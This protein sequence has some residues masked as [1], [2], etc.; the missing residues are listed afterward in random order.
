MPN[1][2]KVLYVYPHDVK[3]VK[4]K[5]YHP[6]LS[7]ILKGYTYLSDD[8]TCVLSSRPLNNLSKIA[9]ETY[10]GNYPIKLIPRFNRL[11][12]SLNLNNLIIK[13]EVE[14]ADLVITK[15]P[16]FEGFIAIKYAK[17]L[18]KKILVEM[19]GCPW[20]SLSNHSFKGKLLAPWMTFLTKKHIKKADYVQ[21][22]S[23]DFLQKRYPTDSLQIGCSDVNILPV[24]SD[25]I[26]KKYKDFHNKETVIL[27]TSA[28]VDIKYK[29]QK[30]IIKLLPE[31]NKGNKIFEYHLAGGGDNS[32]LKDLASKLGVEDKV[33][34]LG[35]LDKEDVN[36]YLEKI[37][38]Y[39][40]PSK[41]EGLSRALVEAM[42]RGCFCIAS[43]VGGNPEL[44]EEE[45][46][47]NV[48][49]PKSIVKIIKA[50][51]QNTITKS[52]QRNY[53]YSK[54]FEPNILRNKLEEF[55]NKILK[56]LGR[57]DKNY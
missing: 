22:V 5:Y 34:F 41:Q 55:Y 23:N 51:N 33:K 43:K 49:N 20:D 46:L 50:L 21:Y 12:K 2:I 13:E 30:E 52:S 54:K 53:E 42:S 8:I 25:L 14:K 48:N 17:E 28:A 3:K 40:Q 44:I 15:L 47:Y 57:I 1:N 31:L 35:L 38:I 27:G 24:S 26:N 29:G 10:I 6:Y 19:V 16:S 36:K 32:K 18:N 45:Y 11:T 4:D 56:D 9:E 37:D 39:I 7:K